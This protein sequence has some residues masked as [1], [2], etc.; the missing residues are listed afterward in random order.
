[1]QLVELH[2]PPVNL[3]LAKVGREQTVGRTFEVGIRRNVLILK[4]KTRVKSHVTSIKPRVKTRV[5][6][7]RGFS[8]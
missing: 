4:S 3:L 1:M 8:I 2:H 5:A 6:K 7:P